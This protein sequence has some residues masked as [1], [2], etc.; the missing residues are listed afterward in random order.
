MADLQSSK[1]LPDELDRAR[2][3]RIYLEMIK[4]TN[5]PCP[6][7]CPP[8]CPRLANGTCPDSD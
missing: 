1:R 4:G 3:T 7:H 6:P 2:A 5:K 8:N